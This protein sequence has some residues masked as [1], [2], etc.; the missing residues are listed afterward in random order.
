MLIVS[1]L[2]YLRSRKGQKLTLLLSAGA[3][4]E[5]EERNERVS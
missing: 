2:I 1:F 3:H 4:N 5:R